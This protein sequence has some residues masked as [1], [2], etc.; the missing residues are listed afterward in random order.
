MNITDIDDKIIRGAAAAGE[1]IETLAERY[2]GRLPGRRRRAPDDDAGRPAPGHPVH[3]RRSSTLIETLLERRPRLPDRRRL[4]LLPDLVVAGLRPAG[5]PRPRR[6]PGGGAGGGRRVRQGRRPRLRPVEG[7]EAGRAGLGDGDRPGPAGLAHRMLGDEH[8]PPR[9]VVRHPHRRHR[10]DLPAPRGRDR[11]ER[12]GDRPD[13][14]RDVAPLRPPPDG[15]L[16]DG[17]V[18]RQHRAGRRLPGRRASRRGPFGWRS[19]RSTTGP[20]STSR[21]TRWPRRA[22]PSSGWMRPSPRSTPTARTARTT[23]TLVEALADGPGRR[24]GR[25]STTTSTC[26]PRSAALFDL[27]RDLNR[28][29]ERRTLSTADAGRALRA[30]PRPGPRPRRSCPT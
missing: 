8:G 21:T 9:T 27:V 13:V 14:R 1:T 28:R 6:A 12:G 25:R 3:R 2:L 11:P 16:E 30:A 5:P 20:R 17:Q 19:S 22:R 18:D 24:S 29:I 4:D 7:P 10:P 26:R 23:P 15:R